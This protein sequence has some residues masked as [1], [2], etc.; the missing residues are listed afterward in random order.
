[1]IMITFNV[2]ILIVI[3]PCYNNY[4]FIELSFIDIKLKYLY[5]VYHSSTTY[6][7]Q[8]LNTKVKLFALWFIDIIQFSF[9]N[10]IV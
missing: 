3:F 1:M 10:N 2:G 6:I 5:N 8:Y 4:Q 9:E 7:I